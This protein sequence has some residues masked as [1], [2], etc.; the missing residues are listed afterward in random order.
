MLAAVLS[1]V[2]A[3]TGLSPLTAS[4]LLAGLLFPIQTLTVT[5][6]CARGAFAVSRIAWSGVLKP[7]INRLVE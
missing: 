4:Y 5:T 2:H 1:A 6:L 3:A 7:A